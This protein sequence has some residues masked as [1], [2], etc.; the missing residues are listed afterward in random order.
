MAFFEENC[1]VFRCIKMPNYRPPCW[2]NYTKGFSSA[3]ELDL[4]FP[5]KPV[6]WTTKQK[7]AVNCCL[8]EYQYD[9]P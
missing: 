4:P 9:R 8:T 6:K 5:V 1:K 7:Y 3:G 2:I